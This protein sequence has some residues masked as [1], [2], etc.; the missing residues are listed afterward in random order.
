MVGLP[1]PIFIFV[2]SF[3][4]KFFSQEDWEVCNNRGGLPQPIFYLSSNLIF[5]LKKRF[6]VS[7]FFLK[8]MWEVCDNSGG[9]A[10]A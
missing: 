8:V 3:G 5:S 4:S 10:R 2:F 1:M 6:L 7:S 9:V